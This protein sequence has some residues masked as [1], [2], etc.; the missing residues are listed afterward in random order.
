[1][2]KENQLLLSMILVLCILVLCYSLYLLNFLYNA[3][4]AENEKLQDICRNKAMDDYNR[5]FARQIVKCK[6]PTD[7]TCL[8]E[9]NG[10]TKTTKYQLN[11]CEKQFPFKRKW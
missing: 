9:V 7:K 6:G 10:L 8:S 3:K 1:M 2:N 11:Q 5:A 4:L